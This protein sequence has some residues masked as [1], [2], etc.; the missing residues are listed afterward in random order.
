MTLLARAFFAVTL[1]LASANA[2]AAAQTT[3]ARPGTGCS[4]RIDSNGSNWIIPGYDPFSG[5]QPTATFD[6]LFFNDG[7]G[8]CRFRPVFM[9]DSAPFGLQ[10]DTGR[11][12]GYTILDTWGQYDATPLGGRTVVRITNRPVVVSA[13][14][15]QLVRYILNVAA[16][17]VPGD[18]LYSQRLIME[19]NQ[20]D[21]TPIASRQ[22]LVG[23]HVL[24]SATMG[25]AGAFRRNGSQ[26]DVDLGDLQP[27]VAPVPL[28]LQIKSTR[29][30]RLG[31]Q[32]LNGGKL[33][34]AG[35]DWAIAYD[36]QIDGKNVA[37]TGDSTLSFGRGGGLRADSLPVVFRIG[38]VDGRRAGIYA[39]TLT[40]S[41]AVE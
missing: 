30:Y 22:F 16:A 20:L 5:N 4:L 40:V 36:L 34:L 7:D 41:V 38:D 1:A 24:P 13:G 10:A 18:G 14:A 19:A 6:V 39:D 26:A 28:A 9:T 15:Q 21:G 2:E 33:R 31:V 29:G 23:I 37:L 3:S 32:S 11:R 12:V 25:L 17:E 27:G 8:E 35:T